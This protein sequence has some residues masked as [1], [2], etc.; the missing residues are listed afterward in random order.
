MATV[1]LALS[2]AFLVLTYVGYPLY[3]ALRARVWPAPPVVRRLADPPPRASILIAAHDEAAHISAKLA[4]CLEQAYPAE[5]LEVVVVSD[6]STDATDDKVAAVA[7]RNRRVRYVRQEHRAGKATALNLAAAVATGDVLVFSDARQRLAPN[8]VRELCA[9]L[10]DPT[11]GAVSGHLVLAGD[12]MSG[13]YWRYERWIR[14]NEARAGSALGVTGA[15]YAIRRGDFIPLPAETVLDDMLVPLRIH[16]G[17]RGNLPRAPRVVTEPLAV[18][19]DE[20]ADTYDEIRRKTRT[21]A[22]N[23]QLLMLLPALLS[24]RRNPSFVAFAAH[25]L[26]RLVA[27]WVLVAA[28]FAG[29][30]A[31]GLFGEVLFCAQLVAYIGAAV[32][33]FGHGGPVCAAAWAFVAMHIAAVAGLGRFV[34]GR[35]TAAWKRSAGPSPPMPTATEGRQSAL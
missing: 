17:P 13:V 7:G 3:V 24:P 10:G 15:L 31:P 16:L 20:A 32:G 25:K 4:S 5:Q 28:F 21:L 30:L 14:D 9:S 27:P 11:V 8:A 23:Y 12:A 18:A 34:T 19:Y 29:M 2:L 22:G 6:A 26:A 1:I 35:V 33:A